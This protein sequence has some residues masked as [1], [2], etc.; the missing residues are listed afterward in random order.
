[1][2]TDTDLAALTWNVEPLVYDKSEAGV[3]ELLERADRLADE[4]EQL[5]GRIQDIDATGLDGMLEL[6]AEL[7]D[8][9]G[10]VSSYAVLRFS[11]KTTDERRG[12]LMQRVQERLTSINTRLTFIELEWAELDDDKVDEL[13]ADERI[14]RARHHLRSAR[15][16]RPH[17]LTEPEERVMSE[18]SLT[19]SSAWA[20]LFAELVSAIEVEIDG[21]NV[22]L[23]DALSRLSSPDREVRRSSAEAVT[24][25]L[26]PGIKTRA[27]VFNT[28]L[29][30]KAVDDRLRSY[31]H[32]LANRN[33]ANEASDESVE[34]LLKAVRAR[35][36]I[37]QR[38]YKLKA[39]VLGIDVLADY[40]RMATVTSDEEV[41]T[42]PD[43]KEIVLDSYQSFSPEVAGVVSRF[44]EGDWIDVPPG[45]GKR[46]GAFCH[47]TVP[48]ANPY[49]LLNFTSKRRDVLTLAH[50]LG[51][52][53]HSYLARKQGIF[54]YGMPLTVAETASV[55]GETIVFNRLLAMEEDAE[56]R[57]AL[58]A[59]NVDGAVATVFRQAAM[60]RFEELVHTARRDEGELAVDRFNELWA[61]SQEEMFGDSLEVTEGYHS[62]WSY[63]PHFVHTPGYVY[64]YAFGQLLALS[65]Y[66]RYQERGDSFVPSYLEML[67]SGG[68]RSPE[69]LAAIVDCDLADP[70]FWNGGLSL[71]D[72]TL[73][74]A[75][76]AARAAGRL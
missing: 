13:L 52:G 18:K 76:E 54:H 10:R 21:D 42:W 46:P 4:L 16:Y 63:I 45:D 8:V 29:Q 50:E 12:A 25:A 64:A 15:R 47:Y 19:G 9:T 23:E 57:F 34:A 33:L 5:R 31:P 68:S 3:D 74:R 2:T 32:W 73:G 28:L 51:H 11:A 56:S 26:Q 14:E 67:A 65:V 30:D 38:Y 60:N 58:L 24:R 44:Y 69:D 40:D 39:R 70:E 49:I 53:I 59:E 27:F 61:E 17:L 72:D 35:H 1:M 7:R 37:P 48:S 22:G 66:K 62:W 75:E 71:I 6:L 36:D 41:V 55:F 43:A 20:R